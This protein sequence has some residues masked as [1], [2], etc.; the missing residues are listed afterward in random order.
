VRRLDYAPS[1]RH[2]AIRLLVGALLTG[3]IFVATIIGV[4][5]ATSP[6]TAD[7]FALPP[8]G[9]DSV[10]GAIRFTTS[11]REDTLIDL[12]RRHALGYDQI[13]KANPKVNRWLPG[14]GTRVL[15]PDRYVLPDTPRDGIVV[16][17]AE[18]RLY[19]FFPPTPDGSQAV[20]TFPVSI[21]RMDWTIPLG[22][23]KVTKTV[24]DPPWYPT[25]SVRAEHAAEGDILPPFVPGGDPENPLGR[26]ALY[27]GI[28]SYLIH[29]VDARKANGIG[30]R[31]THGCIRM[32]PEHIELLYRVVRPGTPVHIVDQPVKVGWEGP[33]LYL[34]VHA[35]LEEDDTE[36]RT[37]TQGDI[38]YVREEVRR[39]AGGRFRTNDGTVRRAAKE[40]NGIPVV[41]GWNLE[42]DSPTPKLPVRPDP[43]SSDY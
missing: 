41:I 1:P 15:L 2:P 32:Y 10:I 37:V 8:D 6:A 34:E 33:I 23:T 43:Y 36:P 27:L 24:K 11:R 9:S 16:N 7:P 12:A 22:T 13:I 35:P 3:R 28:P 14:A 18:L 19:Y 39:Y 4:A 38:N 40:G 20:L 25:A 30:M 17:L 5:S 31:V 21:G 29:G 42:D 26:Y